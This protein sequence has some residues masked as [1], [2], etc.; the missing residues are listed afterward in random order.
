MTLTLRG[1]GR[2]RKKTDL[3]LSGE[4]VGMDRWNESSN[5][6]VGV[7][8]PRLLPRCSLSSVWLKMVVYA[9]GRFIQASQP[10]LFRLGLN[11][12]HRDGYSQARDTFPQHPFC[13][14]LIRLNTHTLFSGATC[15]E[16]LDVPSV[17]VVPWFVR[18][19]PFYILL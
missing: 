17:F 19:L 1:D 3:H 7:Q 9:I 8:G 12:A 15:L 14:T 6:V 16:T 5:F 2:G 13:E 4:G 10:W 11:P 18:C